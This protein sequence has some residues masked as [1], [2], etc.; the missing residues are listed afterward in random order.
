MMP[1]LPGQSVLTWSPSQVLLTSPLVKWTPYLATMATSP[2]AKYSLDLQISYKRTDSGFEDVTAFPASDQ[3]QTA[4]PPK[5]FQDITMPPVE[6]GDL[7][8]ARESSDVQLRQEPERPLPASEPTRGPTLPPTKSELSSF[9]SSLE[10]TRPPRAKGTTPVGS[11]P[12]SLKTSRPSSSSSRD[13]HLRSNPGTC[14]ITRPSKAS[15]SPRNP[16]HPASNRS[17]DTSTYRSGPSS[18][19]RSSVLSV[20]PPISRTESFILARNEPRPIDL[21]GVVRRTR[22][23]HT[24]NPSAL[25][26]CPS[27]E[28]LEDEERPASPIHPPA[29]DYPIDWTGTASRAAQY[30]EIDRRNRGARGLLRRLKRKMKLGKRKIDFYDGGS[31]AGSV[32]RYRLD[33][34]CG[35]KVA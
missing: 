11:K 17:I 33:T 13:S 15:S 1:T 32:R 24:S 35:G 29:P 22:E 27:P 6:I 2:T 25:S 30:A 9:S 4:N 23:Q 28:T 7:P 16:T 20:R 8:V 18:S 26:P 21:E 14:G 31:D 34:D 3:D 10:R 5:P 12:A 19:R